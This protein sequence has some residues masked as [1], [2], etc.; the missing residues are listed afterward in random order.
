MAAPSVTYTFTNATTADA[1]QVNQNFTDIINGITDGTKTLTMGA[2]VVS[3]G[4]ATTLGGAVTLGNSSSNDL[5]F[6][7]SI[8][9]TI[10]IKTNATYNIGSATLGL[11]GIYLGGAST[12]T[13][14]LLSPAVTNTWTL[15]LP[16]D[17]P[18]TA[19][20]FLTST[21]GGAASWLNTDS[22]VASQ[23]TTYTASTETVIPCDATS[24]GFTVALPAAA[25]NIGKKYIIVKT[26]STFNAVT[27]DGNASETIN[28]ATTRTLNTQYEAVQIVCDGANWYL[29]NAY[30]NGAF[31][32][33]TPTFTGLGTVTNNVSFWRR[34]ADSIEIIGRTTAGTAAASTA[35]LTLPTGLSIDTAKTS[36][37][38]NFVAGNG[39]VATTTPL[40]INVI[41]SPGT[42]T[43]ILY[44]TRGS[45]LMNGSTLL[46]NSEIVQFS[47]KVPISGWN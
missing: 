16:V 26:D 23:T 35:S 2:L 1:T 31:T 4:G 32:S 18:S 22:F 33:Y 3:T 43:T 20:R 28:G 24:A 15:T 13:V 38:L 42:S 39:F 34:L 9:S 6:N 14:R 46:G 5:T 25:S 40:A 36:A 44:L 12:K 19:G 41:T 7:G 8:A 27:I 29:T 45:S 10:P 11:L 37:S 47:I 30:T 21:T 17:V